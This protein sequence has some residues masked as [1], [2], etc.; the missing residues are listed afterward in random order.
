MDFALQAALLGAVMGSAILAVSTIY[1]W[2]LPAAPVAYGWWAA[3][4]VLETASK[5]VLLGGATPLLIEL[6]DVFHGLAAGL[7][8]VGARVLAG[9]RL[10]SN[11][12]GAGLVAS[13]GWYF[14]AEEL[15]NR[16][17]LVELPLFGI[18]GLPLLYAG[19]TFFR[20]S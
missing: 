10:T 13:F 2:T 15:R 8:L 11:F 3:A 4:F 9:H 19:W 20:L 16:L 17:G 12:L 1:G 6:S 7:V 18:G 14:L 5:G